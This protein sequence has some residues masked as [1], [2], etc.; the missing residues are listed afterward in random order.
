MIISLG[1]L[2]GLHGRNVEMVFVGGGAC[3]DGKCGEPSIRYW[4]QGVLGAW[5]AFRR[6]ARACLVHRFQNQP[7]G[8]SSYGCRSCC[9][10]PFLHQSLYPPFSRSYIVL[11]ELH[12]NIELHLYLLFSKLAIQRRLISMST[13]IQCWIS[14]P[15]N[16]IVGSVCVEYVITLWDPKY[17]MYQGDKMSRPCIISCFSF[18]HGWLDMHQCSCSMHV[19]TSRVSTNTL[20]FIVK[21]FKVC[22]TFVKLVGQVLLMSLTLL[23]SH[24][25]N[26]MISLPPSCL[27]SILSFST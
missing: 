3:G 9:K 18:V 21:N 4:A 5:G 15:S 10:W 11:L 14:R 22:S 19:H 25:C 1:I 12:R 17:Y 24:T 2:R 13:R 27:P 20:D 26:L 23:C 6:G 8:L 16:Y 7:M